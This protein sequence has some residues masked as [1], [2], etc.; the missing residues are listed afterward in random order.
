MRTHLHEEVS[1]E[2][3]KVDLGHASICSCSA[4]QSHAAVLILTADAYL[5]A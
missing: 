4:E 1:A 5:P 3:M 2:L